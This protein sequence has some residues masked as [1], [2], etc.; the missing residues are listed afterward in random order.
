[1]TP[2]QK[3]PWCWIAP[4]AGYRLLMAV[5]RP[6]RASFRPWRIGKFSPRMTMAALVIAVTSCGV[7]VI[8]HRIT[9]PNLSRYLGL[10]P[11]NE[12]GGVW[13]AAVIFPVVNALCEELVFRGVLYDALESYVGSWTGIMGSALVF[14][15]LHQQGYPPGGLGVLLASI[16][17]IAL[18]WLR[19]RVKGL[20][21][22]VLTHITADLTIFVIFVRN[23]VFA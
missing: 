16:Y 5:V 11:V 2:L 17:G 13:T 3:W 21:L 1:M 23:G 12:L 10:L 7:L 22:P 15:W 4:L 6:L 19:M 8:F 20:G 18:G 9:Q 14:G